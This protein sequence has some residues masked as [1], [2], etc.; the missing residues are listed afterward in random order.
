M[1]KLDKTDL[2][3]GLI[4]VA[5]GLY[6]TVGA[7]D[8]RMGT[9]TRMGPGFIPVSLGVVCI[10]LGLAVG[11]VSLGREGALPEVHWRAVVPVIA[12][13]AAFALIL[14]RA[15]MLPAIAVTVGIAALASP[16]SR[17]LPT[18]LVALCVGLLLW[19]GFIKILGMPI[20]VLRSPF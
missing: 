17:P 1:L 8:Y 15:G 9:L 13:I 4:L 7:L 3:S 6:F 5:I 16:R 14:P 11:I 10:V 2:V 20:P 12:S 19:V 18:A